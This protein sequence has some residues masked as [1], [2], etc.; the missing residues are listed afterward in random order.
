MNYSKMVKEALKASIKCSNTCRLYM[1]LILIFYIAFDYGGPLS[2]SFAKAFLFGDVTQYYLK[3]R[4]YYKGF[5]QC[6][7]EATKKKRNVLETEKT[8]R[9]SDTKHINFVFNLKI[10]Y[11]FVAILL[12]LGG[13]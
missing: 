4:L 2:T 13:L 10:L 7:D 1:I 11:A 5:Q 3:Y 8:F 9:R 6:E 12:S